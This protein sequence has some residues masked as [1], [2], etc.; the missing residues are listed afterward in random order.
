MCVCMGVCICVCVLRQRTLPATSALEAAPRSSKL[1]PNIC[2][3]YDY[4]CLAPA[5]ESDEDLVLDLEDL[6]LEDASCCVCS[7]LQCVAQ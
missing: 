4:S 3:Y 2:L 7:V 5:L 1:T 6:V